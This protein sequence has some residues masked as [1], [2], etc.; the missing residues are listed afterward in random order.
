MQIV[1][2]M[3]NLVIVL[4]KGCLKRAKSKKLKN[5]KTTSIIFVFKKLSFIIVI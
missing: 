1:K 4:K 3:L 5:Y 2:V